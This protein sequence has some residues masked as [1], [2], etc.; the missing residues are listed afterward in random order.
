[1]RVGTDCL[2]VRMRL[3]STFYPVV[4]MISLDGLYEAIVSPELG[5]APLRLSICLVHNLIRRG[6]GTVRVSSLHLHGRSLRK[7]IT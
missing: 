5:D 4:E 6:K 1:M 3:V 7:N 2:E